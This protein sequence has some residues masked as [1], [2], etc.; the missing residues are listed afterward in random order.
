VRYIAPIVLLA[1]GLSGFCAVRAQQSSQAEA[2]NYIKLS[3]SQWAEVELTRD[4]AVVERILAD[5]FVGVAPD[6]L[7][8]TKANEVHSAKSPERQCISNHLVDIKVRF[9]GDTAVAQGSEA[10]EKRGGV[11]GRYVWAD[12]WIRRNGKGQI[13]AAED[14]QVLGS[15]K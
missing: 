1:L 10:W 5:D 3:E 12:T 9:Y 6:G 11:H 15:P 7:H 14:V 4:A 8:Y 2:E 13:V